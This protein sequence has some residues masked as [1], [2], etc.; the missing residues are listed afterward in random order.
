M[1][2]R[3][4]RESGREV[5]RGYLGIHG[6]ILIYEFQNVR[7][8]CTQ[9]FPAL[10]VGVESESDRVGNIERTALARK[11]LA[12][13]PNLLFC[14]WKKKANGLVV[15]ARHA[16]DVRGPGDRVLVKLGADLVRDIDADFTARFD[17]VWTGRLPLA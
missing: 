10:E 4:R 15:P 3:V 11:K 16:K 12:E 14:L 5:G 17:S 6:L 2:R 1:F 13:Q 7:H 9:C 8:R